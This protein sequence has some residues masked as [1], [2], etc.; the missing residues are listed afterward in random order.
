MLTACSN[1]N[2]V[3]PQGRERSIANFVS[4]EL[5]ESLFGVSSLGP[6]ADFIFRLITVFLD[7]GLVHLVVISHR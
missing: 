4:M 3:R 6:S 5:S 7:L 1:F 2:K